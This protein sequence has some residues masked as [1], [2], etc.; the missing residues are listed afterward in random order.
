[1]NS[2]LRSYVSFV[3]L[4]RRA[5]GIVFVVLGLLAASRIAE[6]AARS[7]Y[8]KN[9]ERVVE[10]KSAE[11]LAAVKTE[12]TGVQRKTRRIASELARHE[13]VTGYLAGKT[14][15]TSRLFEQVAKISRNQDVGAEVFDRSGKLIAWQGRSG[16]VNQ[17]EIQIALQGVLTSYI[18]RGPIYSQLFVITPVRADGAVLGAVLI[19]QTVEVNYPLS[20]KF[21]TRAGLAEQLSRDLGVTVE[22]NYGEN[23][24][25]RK[26]GRFV[27]TVLTGIDGRKLGVASILRLARSNYLENVSGKFQKLNAF[28]LLLLIV[29]IALASAQFLSRMKSV[30]WRSLAVT[31][32]I[33]LGRYV[34]LWLEIPSVFVQSGIFDPSFFA[35]KFGGGLAKSIG[36]MTLTS[37]ALFANTAIITHLVLSNASHRSGQRR[38]LFLPLRIMLAVLI[39]TCI[40]LMLRGYAAA[41]RSAVFDSNLR[42]NDPKVIIPSFQLGLMVFNLFVISFC[43]IIVAVALTSFIVSL[44][45]SETRSRKWLPWSVATVLFIVAAILFDVVQETPLM[46]TGFR[47]FFGAGILVF[48]LYLQRRRRRK[49][50]SVSFANAVIVLALSAI[51][52]YPLLDEVIQEKDRDRVEV[53]AREVLRP[54]DAWLKFVVDEALQSFVSDE[55]FDVLLNGDMEEIER[56]AFTC[57]AKSNAA[58][59][60]YNCSFTILN[61]GGYEISRFAIGEQTSAA[62]QV[63]DSALYEET[64]HVQVRQIGSG[65]NAVKIYSG[66]MPIIASDQ[67]LGYGVVVISAAQQALFRGETPSVFRTASQENLESFY[68]PIRV[69]EFRNGALFTTN[70]A[71]LPIGYRMPKEVE[72]LLSDSLT[73]SLW[74]REVISG[75]EY[76]TLFV[77]RAPKSEQVVALRLEELSA[78]WHL[79]GIVRTLVYY[80]I[81]LLGAVVA[82]LLFQW[83]RGK[84]YA[85]T[86]RDKL[87]IALMV[88][89]AVPVIIISNYTRVFARER[90]MEN[91]SQRLN[92]ETSAV[93]ESL[94]HGNIQ[95][96]SGIRDDASV[97]AERL[98]AKMKA[99][100]NFYAGNTLRMS[101]RPE[102]YETGILDRRL[103]GSAY[104]SIFVKGERFHLETENIGLYRY[105]VGY[106]PLQDNAG[107]ITGVIS[108]PTLYRQEQIDEDAARTNAVLFGVSAIIFIAI[109]LIATT[110]ANRI[111]SPIHKLT[112][113]TKRVSLGDLD[114]RVHARADGEIGELIR[115]FETMTKDLKRSREN[116][117]QYERELAWKEMAKQ[118]AHEIKNPLT[119]MKLAL[120]HLRQTYRDKVE[121]FDEVFEE[122]SQMVIRQVDALS[123]I[124]SEF[125][126]FARMPK[127]RLEKC[128]VND[129]LREAI[130]LFEQDERVRIETHLEQHLPPIMADREELRRAFINIIRNG[131]QA[132]NNEGRMIVT[133]AKLEHDIEVRIQDFGCGIRNEIKDKLFQPNFSTKTDGM[134]LGLAIVK[135]TIEDLNG[136]ISIESKLDEGTTVILHIPHKAES[137]EPDSHHTS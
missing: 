8:S 129:V 137:H 22:I 27:S 90:L 113:A 86:F 11:Q 119:P 44:F 38:K 75:K 101:S 69:S 123:R 48:A 106:R 60:G 28:L 47:L 42:F 120:Q 54:A 12:F 103:S 97:V 135:K 124:A 80:T 107:K 127:A 52:F 88:T 71:S 9:W 111:A 56:L 1:M 15:E 136:G 79:F 58:K 126:S 116:L 77:R 63:T 46:S 13:D 33:W 110:F 115:S 72:S 83:A 14:N 53:F 74:Y 132:M 17:R 117:V 7:Y 104:A 65:V 34:L 82:L 20:N 16:V 122:V 4:Q 41:I 87:L 35:S 114:V 89:A 36:E 121:N 92:Q 40:F 68:R 29:I 73:A 26:D 130:Y 70:D 112:E 76:E 66:S 128:S 62:L 10:S 94:L 64:Q 91:L 21:I 18:T 3:P 118:V 125:S 25:A 108:V 99:D 51:F 50:F 61:P 134:G 102:L 30:L 2:R 57:W 6:Y 85:L 100:F 32:L 59:Q 78:A 55:A 24:E 93:E 109:S 45:E 105:A 96:G 19:R 81:V 67:V 31:I 23:A 49:E 131:I 84:P 43:L 95:D 5:F 98:A 37:L 133:S 39:T